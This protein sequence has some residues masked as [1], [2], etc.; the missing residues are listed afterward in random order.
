MSVRLRRQLSL[1]PEVSGAPVQPHSP[2]LPP[3][4]AVPSLGKLATTVVAGGGPPLVGL[5]G[6]GVNPLNATLFMKFR[7]LAWVM[8]VASDAFEV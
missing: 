1:V 6:V 8:L 3:W 7:Q 2:V 5:V 4:L